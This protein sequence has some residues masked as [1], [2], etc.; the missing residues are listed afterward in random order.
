MLGILVGGRR[1]TDDSKRNLTDPS[2]CFSSARERFHAPPSDRGRGRIFPLKH[3][4]VRYSSSEGSMHS[5]RRA[6]P[7]AH[8]GLGKDGSWTWGARGVLRRGA[9]SRWRHI[10]VLGHADSQKGEWGSGTPSPRPRPETANAGGTD[11]SLFPFLNPRSPVVIVIPSLSLIV[12]GV[13]VCSNRVRSCEDPACGEA[14]CEHPSQ[15][16]LS[17]VEAHLVSEEACLGPASV[18]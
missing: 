18:G 3:R 10:L 11:L 17:G 5:A 15:T 9:S 12:R 13:S 8:P 7:P 14:L 6:L 4:P 1:S 16:T 2:R